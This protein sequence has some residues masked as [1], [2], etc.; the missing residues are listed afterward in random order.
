M[1][2]NRKIYKTELDGEPLELEVSELARKANA[3]V[4]GRHGD[5]VVLAT[6]VMGKHDR[7]GDFFPL[8]VDYE[9]R[10]YAA[11]RIMGSRFMRREGRPSDKATLSARLIDRTI[12][13]LFDERLR[14]EIQVTVTILAYDGKNDPDVIALLATSA[15]LSI[16]DIPWGGPVAGVR[17]ASRTPDNELEYDAF[18]C[19]TE[20]RI[21]MIEF[22][23]NEVSEDKAAT[24][25]SGAQEEIKRLIGFQK[26]IIKEISKTKTEI[27]LKDPDPRIKKLVLDFIKNDLETAIKEK[28]LGDLNNSLFEHLRGLDEDSDTLQ[29]A[30]N[31]FENEVNVYVHKQALDK[32]KRADDRKLDEVRDLYSEVGLFERTHGSGLFIRGDTQILA[33]TTLAPPSAEQLI[34]TIEEGI[35]KKRFMLHYNF[36]KFSVGEVGRSRGP[37]R[38]DIGHGTL[39][40]KAVRAMLP[41][42]EEFPY[43]IRVVAE[44][45]SSNGSSSMASACAASLS[46]MDAG[47]PMKKHVAGIAMG[48]ML[49]ND[50]GKFKVLTDIQGPE[51]HHGDMDLKIAGTEE[52]ITAIQMD[53]KVEGITKEIFEV[54]LAQAR[55]ARL[56]I[57]KTMKKILPEPRSQVSPHAPTILTLDIDPDRIGD[58]IGPGGKTINH[59][60]ALSGGEVTIDIEQTGKVFVAGVGRELVEK[61]LEFVKEIVKEYK[62]GDVVEGPIIKTLD[63]GAI[64]DLGGGRDGMIHVSELKEGFVKKV[65]DVVK[66]GDQVKAKVVKIERGKIGLSLKNVK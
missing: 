5:T 19:G 65:E 66:L 30:D 64:V 54:T 62:V 8:T 55:G 34:E 33:I 50:S 16:S 32:E 59:I 26:N 46:L 10:F 63:F 18:F 24:L 13:P 3:A 57:L 60:I 58:V 27:E 21:N 15:A 31:V 29:L 41:T 6:V 2:L 47:V 37:G 22:E 35:G 12:R 39:A 40:A 56:H 4:L 45:L 43:T 38:R 61:A 1:D 28:T 25:F 7:P 36:P 23:G 17:Q 53:V 9:E 20:G 51:D 52:G 44:T 48:L 11:G 42:K 14:R 49:D